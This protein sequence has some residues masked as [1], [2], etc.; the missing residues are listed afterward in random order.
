MVKLAE[1]NHN[2][3]EIIEKD[4]IKYIDFTNT[5]PRN[6]EIIKEYANGKSYKELSEKYGIC[7]KT[8][9]GMVS[10]YVGKVR[11]YCFNNGIKL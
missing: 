5:I 6:K 3:K 11:R 10:S 4:M 7:V 1:R 8:I 9:A 2:R